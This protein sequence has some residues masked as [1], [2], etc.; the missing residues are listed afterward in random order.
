VRILVT[1][2]LSSLILSKIIYGVFWQITYQS[3]LQEIIA[4]ECENRNRPEMK[5]NGKCYLSKQ[6]KKIELEIDQKK[7]KNNRSLKV[8]KSIEG[9]VYLFSN[10]SKFFILN[11]DDEKETVQISDY[12]LSFSS[13]H[14]SQ[15]FHPPC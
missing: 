2:F 6:L 10:F 8:V 11:N 14:L 1:I 13:G 4:K 12:Q 5:C 3:N 9:S 15:V 7:E